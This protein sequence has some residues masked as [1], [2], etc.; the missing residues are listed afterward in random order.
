MFSRRAIVNAS[1]AAAF[2]L[3]SLGISPRSAGQGLQQKLEAQY[4]LT[5]TT[6]DKT[7]IVTA[8]AILILQKDKLI[9]YPTTTQIPPQNTYKDGRLSS[10][11]FGA[12]QSIQKFGSLIGHAP[13]SQLQ[14]AS[15]NFVTG[16]KF[17]VTKI[18]VQPDG[19]VFTLFTDAIQDVRYYSTLKF[20]YPKGST[21]STDQVMSTVAEV[22]KVQP[23]EDAKSDDKGGDQQQGAAGGNANQQPPAEQAPAAPPAT[24]GIGQTVDEVVAILGQPDKI[25]NLG[26]KQIYVYKDLKVTFVKGKVTD[27]Q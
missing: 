16:E 21:P 22:L 18:D 10:G 13:P 6:D 7:D 1:L 11:A 5:K 12:H 17:W 23:D 15:R 4:A 14:T 25:I 24:V 9:M 26:P 3:S 27:A 20:V 2:I 8:G 19:V